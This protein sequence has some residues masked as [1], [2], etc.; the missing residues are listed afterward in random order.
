MESWQEAVSS[1][2]HDHL[3][4]ELCRDCIPVYLQMNCRYLQLI[5]S[6]LQFFFTD[7]CEYLQ[8][9]VKELQTRSL[10]Y[11]GVQMPTEMGSFAWVSL[12]GQVQTSAKVDAVRK[13]GVGGDAIFCQITLDTCRYLTVW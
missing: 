12:W 11:M 9:P 1:T 2:K 13:V 7:I 3:Q 5:C 10:Y 6:C 8:I 4:A